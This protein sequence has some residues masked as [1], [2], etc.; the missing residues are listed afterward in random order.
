[1]IIIMMIVY[2]FRSVPAP[3]YKCSPFV[4]TSPLSKMITLVSPFNPYN[5][6]EHNNY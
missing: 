5:K 6:I 4:R 3:D 2:L 1:M